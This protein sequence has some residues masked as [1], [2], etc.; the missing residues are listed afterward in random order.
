MPE[1]W[2]SGAVPGVM[3]ELMPAAH[4]VLHA[5]ED[6]KVVAELDRTQ[7]WATIG[8]SASIGFHLRHIAGSSDRLL[9][10]ARGEPLSAAQQAALADERRPATADAHALLHAALAALDTIL[11][12]LRKT[13][14]AVL[15]ER[16]VV[17][18]A[19]LPSNVFGLLCHAAE[20][21]ARHAGQV[22]TLSK[23]VK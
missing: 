21:A 5:K 11:D 3:R 18:R 19:Q 20:H 16:R 9:T 13:D 6:L 23:I 4:M 17:G 1:A 14:P 15:F 8:G 2:L 22:V 7:L 12:T 10:Y